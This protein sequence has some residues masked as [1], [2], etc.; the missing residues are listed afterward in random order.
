MWVNE[1]RLSNINETGAYAALGRIDITLADLGKLSVSA[2]IQTQGFG[3]IESKIQERSRENLTQF[4]AALNI[5]AGKL[6]PKEAKITLPVFASISKTIRTPQ[7]DPY[8]KDV[9]YK[10]KINSAASSSKRD[11]I[12]NLSL[13]QTTIKTINVTNM[14]VA[15]GLTNKLWSLSNFDLSFSYT[16]TT[17]SSPTVTENKV[18]KYRGALGYSYQSQAK[19]IEPFKKIIKSKSKWLNLI[20]DFNF[21]PMPSTIGFRADVNRQFGRFI[22]RII[23]TDL[24][25]SKIQR[26]D[27]TYDKYFT[28]DRFYNV[29]WD[30]SKS[31]NLDFNATN[32][33]RVDEPFGV[34]DTKAKRDSVRDNFFNGGRNTL[35]NQK[36]TAS[37]TLPLNKFPLT[38]WITARYGYTTTYNWIGASRVAIELGNIIENSQDNTMTAQFDL[39]RL[40]SKSRFLR[41]LDNP[42]PKGTEP[43]PITDLLK[44]LPTKEVALLG[45]EGK[46]RTDALAKWKKQRRDAKS[47][48]R[49]QRQ[50]QQ[51]AMGPIVRAAG[52]VLTML[53][54]IQLNYT[55]NYK[56]RIPGYMDST[57]SFGQNFN[58]MQPGLDYVFGKQPDS[59]WLERKA[60]AGLFSLDSNFNLLFRQNFEQKLSINAQLEPI[61]EFTVDI[62]LEKSFSKEYTELFKDTLFNNKSNSKQHLNPYASGGFSVSFISFSTLF[63]A[64]NPNEVSEIFK[65]FQSYRPIISKRLAA[66]NPYWAA[67]G[68]TV[69]GN[70][71]ASGYGKYSQDVLVPSFIAAYTKKDPNTVSLIKQNNSSVK[72]NPFAGILPKPNWRLNY[73]GLSKIPALAKKFTSINITHQYSGTL[74]MNSYTSALQFADP[75]RYGA[76]QFRI[77]DTGNYVPFFLVPNITIQEQ[78]QPLIGIDITTTN[79]L[80]LKFEYK[81]SRILS[82]SLVDYQ[83]SETN[84]TEWTIGASFRK[85][86]VK[87]PAFLMKLI[88][89]KE[90]LEND[91]S[92][93]LDLSMR[94]E[95]TSNSRLD[96]P[97]AYGTG[98]QKVITIQPALDYVINNRIN[99]KIFFDQRK[100]I[101]YISTAAPTTNTRAG[102]QVRVSLQ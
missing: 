49:I 25:S 28:F 86:G 76:P 79:Q 58:S 14:K 81:K 50:N 27:T 98:G 38:E 91:L 1:L 101:P 63:G 20:K 13:D 36:S 37:Y 70:G 69:D 61:R 26:V 34:L 3:S 66:E 54:T 2:N 80:N 90:K 95:A 43:A 7:F 84:A 29:R 23:N 96:Q 74:S 78:F 30:I 68:G 73:T 11:S 33:A 35:Y 48:M 32:N 56:S 75:F 67:Q 55:E 64:V 72:N 83:L 24:T 31:L 60:A 40:Y 41:N 53:K 100:I 77:G 44:N 6:L 85:K 5:D 57:Q 93:K 52:K 18:D 62:T 39:T 99:L 10:D 17:N 21:N 82:L 16:Q 42:L 92:F 19:Y 88:S 102:I 45:L 12:K 65:T 9:L 22:P 59:R 15:P 46:K 47:G 94:D 71:Y 97:N 4:D 87:L 89:K 8:D 51:M